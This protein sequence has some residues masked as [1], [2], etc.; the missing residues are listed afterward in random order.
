M[1][2]GSEATIVCDVDDTLIFWDEHSQRE[3][4]EPGIRVVIQDPNDGMITNHK[5]HYRHVKFLKKQSAK[6]FTVIVWSASGAKWAGA[7]VMALGLQKYVSAAIA[8]PL[9]Y[10]D[11]HPEPQQILGTHIFLD[12]KGYSL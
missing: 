10:V 11:D 12:P 8:K 4:P 6:G 9:K 1:I 7:V 3:N 2:V 5:V